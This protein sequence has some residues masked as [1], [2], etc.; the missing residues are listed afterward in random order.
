MKIRRAHYPLAVLCRVFDVSRSGYHAFASRAP[1][2]RA[3]E[4]ARLEVAIQA[5]HRRTRESYGPE[6][7]QDELKDDGVTVG[8]GR[9]KR[10]G[11]KARPSLQTGA[12]VQGH[13]KLESQF[14]GGAEP[15]R[16]EL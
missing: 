7:L 10:L 9:I 11:K 16:T 6:R 4:N 8:I 15:A 3:R 1:S 5:A 14:S 12:Q 2:K 13:D